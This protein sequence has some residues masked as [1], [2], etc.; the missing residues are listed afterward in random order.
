MSRRE[1]P[2]VALGAAALV[3]IAALFIAGRM[4]WASL[5]SRAGASV[6]V[7]AAPIA[8]IDRDGERLGC[9]SDVPC[10]AVAGDRVVTTDGCVV[11]PGAM[12]AAMRLFAGLKI[13]V[14]TATAADLARVDGISA[15]LAQHIVDMREERG[16]L[17]AIEQLGAI[18]G[19]GPATL[20]TLQKHL[21]AD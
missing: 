20:E 19:V 8:I 5:P 12:S 4:L 15:A 10:T 6:P 21:T 17:D 7:C 13:N 3:A 2:S 14:N 1:G 16:R 11:V 18:S 9:A